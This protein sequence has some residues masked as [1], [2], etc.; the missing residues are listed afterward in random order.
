VESLKIRLDMMF[1]E[2]VQR[3]VAREER[4]A[5]FVLRFLGARAKKAARCNPRTP[6]F[7]RKANSLFQAVQD[8]ARAKVVH[9]RSAI[10]A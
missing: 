2:I 3:I 10:R 5:F 7:R 8:S 6:L 1:E 4:Q 9:R